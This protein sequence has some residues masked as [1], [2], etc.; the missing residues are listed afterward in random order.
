MKRTLLAAALALGLAAPALAA[1]EVKPLFVNED[2]PVQVT[3]SGPIRTIMR[4][5][6]R[7]KAPYKAT[8]QANGE[9]HAIELSARGISRRKYSCKFPPLRV[10]FTDPPATGSLFEGQHKLKLVV[11][12]ENTD[13]FEQMTL[14]EF[15]AYRLYNIL[16]PESFRVR[17]AHVTY[18]DGSRQVASRWAFF[19]E[20]I[21]DVAGRMGGKEVHVPSIPG[22]ALDPDDGARVALFNY[23]VANGDW[24][25]LDGPADE[26][27]CHNSKLVGA[28]SRARGSLTPV[29]Y[30]FDITGLVDPPYAVPAVQMHINSI[31]TRRYWGLCRHNAEVLK[32]APAFLAARPAMER[33]IQAIPG[34]DQRSRDSMI[35]F[36]GGFFEDIATPDSI[37]KKLLD[38]CR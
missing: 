21:D 9:T 18:L 13:R 14:K 29:P 38:D 32:L 8:L 2:S 34:L 35:R 5:A 3:I 10:E 27:C 11:H 23:M 36:L 4:R 15:A 24:G 19:I 17:L 22:Q 20:D 26:D 31:R 30:D 7:S 1:D 6:K 12:C 25:F 33:E 37:E 16:T 28:T